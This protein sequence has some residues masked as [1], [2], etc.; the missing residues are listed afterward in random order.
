LKNLVNQ[1]I[2]GF[3]LCLF[4]RKKECAVNW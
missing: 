4:N 2:Q 1:G 3:F